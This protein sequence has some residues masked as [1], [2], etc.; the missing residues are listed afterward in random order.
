VR[1]QRKGIKKRRRC[2]I[3]VTSVA[4]AYSVGRSSEKPASAFAMIPSPTRRPK[5]KIGLAVMF[6]FKESWDEMSLMLK[7]ISLISV[8]SLEI[9]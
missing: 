3:L 7:G 4:F 6:S 9:R 8:L 5:V 1:D 2:D